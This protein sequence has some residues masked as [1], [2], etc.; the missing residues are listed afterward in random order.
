MR[1]TVNI[2]IFVT[3]LALCFAAL[4]M[5][6]PPPRVE[7]VSPKLAYLADHADDF[8]VFFLGSSRTYRQIIP[9]VFDQLMAEG[10][11]PVRSFNLGVEGMRPPEDTYVF[12]KALARRTTPLKLVLVESNAIR[13]AVRDGDD[14]TLRATYWHDTKRTMTLFRRAFLADKKKRNW[15][16]RIGKLAEQAAQFAEHAMYWLENTSHAGRGHEMLGSW[17]SP[18]GPN[19]LHLHDLG[20][21]LDGYSRSLANARMDPASV[22]AYEKAI[23]GMIEK[24]PRADFGGSVDQAEVREKKRLIESHGGRMFVVIPPY[25]GTKF[26]L[27]EPGPDA[28]PALE[29]WNPK[30]YPDLFATENHSD[31][32]HVNHAGAERYTRHIV[33]ELLKHLSR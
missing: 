11:H 7:I 17:L 5:F 26:F 32:G 13:L 10:G 24:P 15:R 1:A 23:A 33:R 25:A 14:G 29:F 21:R 8:D 12:E 20:P 18:G 6:T 31:A 30:L 22:P 9:E 4:G 19:P 2:A 27:P 16:D 28:P 3:A